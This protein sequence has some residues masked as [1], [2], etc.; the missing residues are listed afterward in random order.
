MATFQGSEKRDIGFAG[1]TILFFQENAGSI[2]LLFFSGR[3]AFGSFCLFYVIFGG[4]LEGLWDVFL[5]EVFTSFLQI[6]H[7]V[8]KWFA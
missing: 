8:L 1:P 6:L 4:S 2:L 3:S 7:I 5:L